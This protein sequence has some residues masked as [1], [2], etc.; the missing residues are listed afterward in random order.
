MKIWILN[1]HA[2][3]PDM[4]GGTRHYEISK[5]LVEKG[6]KVT[7][8]SSSFHYALFKDFRKYKD[9]FFLKEKIDG[10][11]WFWIK[12]PTY[13]SNNL[14]RLVNML[15][16]F[17]RVIKIGKK[18]G[19]NMPPDIIIGSTVH[20]FTPLAAIKLKK[21]FKKPYIFEIRDLWPQT[22][23]DM[24]VWNKTSLL[25]KMFFKIEK[26]SVINADGIIALSPL[27]SKYV[28][29]KYNFDKVSYIPNGIDINTYDKRLKKFSE[30]NLNIDTLK[31]LDK[32]KQKGY[33]IIEFIGSVNIS[34]N[35][36]F[37]I[38]IAQNL[39]KNN[40]KYYIAIIGKGQK[41]KH[42][43]NIIKDKKLKNI[44]FFEP[45]S[46]KFV[47]VLLQKSD[48]L[49]LIQGKVMWGSMNKL[50][51][52]MASGKPIISVVENI[53]NNPIKNIAPE[54]DVSEKN[55]S[56]TMKAFNFLSKMDD[57]TLKVYKS[58]I[59]DVLKKNYEISVLTDKFLDFIENF[60]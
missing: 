25:S 58:K 38:N 52:Y 7:V 50:F 53:H 49:L 2:L 18:I 55:I 35:I 6:H 24:Q 40:L 43:I 16:Y 22:M 3:S 11:D 46:K 12:T 29:N 60:K 31:K 59:R 45:V 1:H 13:S 34:N 48:A 21:F 57:K 36:D 33:K 17:Q 44:N 20:P 37:I 56:N 26:K 28:K 32:I 30:K 5:K 47:P 19:K 42:Y 41:I 4:P 9:D 14:K 39:Q 27:T 15:F 10:I 8:F 51:D 54:L 23:I